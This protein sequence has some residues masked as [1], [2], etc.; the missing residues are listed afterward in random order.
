MSTHTKSV[1]GWIC[2]GLVSAFTLF[3]AA[4][5]FVTFT[6]KTSLDM[7]AKLGVGDIAHELGIAK[8]ILVLIYLVPR[9][10]TVGFVLMIGYYGG[11]LATN[12]THG[13]TIA[14]YSPILIAFVLMTVD[15]YC[16]KPELL[17]RIRGKKI[18]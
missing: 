15:A 5:E 8:I 12:I 14:E 18:A 16:R 3:S 6:D 10:S 1:I 13:F 17:D 9:T 2:T 7:I 11:A 4:M